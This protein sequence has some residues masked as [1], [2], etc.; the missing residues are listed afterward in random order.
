[1]TTKLVGLLAK[2]RI[3]QKRVNTAHESM[4]LK[5]KYIL[6]RIAPICNNFLIFKGIKMGRK[7]K[8]V[9]LE[10][11]VLTTESEQPLNTHQDM[12]ATHVH[13]CMKES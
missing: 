6:D 3:T 10:N 12:G 13:I 8:K 7:Y 9:P 4:G 1:M 5:S 11:N 2:L